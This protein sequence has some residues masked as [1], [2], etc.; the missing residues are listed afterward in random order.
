MAAA[1]IEAAA[2]L[3]PAATGTPPSP[4]P[5]GHAA[6]RLAAGA[7]H[8]PRAPALYLGLFCA[9]FGRMQACSA[10]MTGEPALQILWPK[11]PR[12]GEPQRRT[13]REG[14]EVKLLEK[15]QKGENP[16]SRSGNGKVCPKS[17]PSARSPLFLT[18]LE[19]GRD[20]TWLRRGC[21]RR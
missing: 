4:F 16:K 6:L 11:L 20:A 5:E 21:F 9:S 7:E 3:S 14:S 15:R 18:S 2:P 13:G 1:R 19:L 10:S 8:C 12:E 17:S